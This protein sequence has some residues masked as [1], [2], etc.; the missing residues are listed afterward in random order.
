[1]SVSPMVI[2]PSMSMG[3]QSGTVSENSSSSFSRAAGMGIV[4]GAGREAR[5]LQAA[6]AARAAFDGGA[7][8]ALLRGRP[9]GG[10]G[11]EVV[12]EEEGVDVAGTGAGAGAASSSSS[13]QMNGRFAIVDDCLVMVYLGM[14][15]N[16][17]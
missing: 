7:V 12:E 11:G 15:V 10:D 8:V 5:V 2:S 13:S 14:L 9:L 17:V 6:A 4:A 3:S 1:M 16:E